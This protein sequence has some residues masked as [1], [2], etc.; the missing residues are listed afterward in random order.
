MS[1]AA[2]IAQVVQ[3]MLFIWA[4]QLGQSGMGSNTDLQSEVSDGSVVKA[5]VSET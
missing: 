2:Q 4:G 3:P 5:S 1:I